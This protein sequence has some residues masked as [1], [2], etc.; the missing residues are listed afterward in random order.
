MK[1][2]SVEVIEAPCAGNIPHYASLHLHISSKKAKVKFKKKKKKVLPK[3][4]HD[5]H[6]FHFSLILPGYFALRYKT[7]KELD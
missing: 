6:S 5:M 7:F 4:P 1:V 3:C 2:A